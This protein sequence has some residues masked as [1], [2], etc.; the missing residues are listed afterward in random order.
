MPPRGF[1]EKQAAT[2]ESRLREE[3]PGHESRVDLSVDYHSMEFD[4]DESIVGHW[5]VS[6][7][8]PEVLEETVSKVRYLLELAASYREP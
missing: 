1:A 2:L 8:G 3:F 6:A 5:T 4:D 7:F